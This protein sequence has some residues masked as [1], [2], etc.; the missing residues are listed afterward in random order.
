MK[1][2]LLRIADTIAHHV[3]LRKEVRAEAKIA[4]LDGERIYIDPLKDQDF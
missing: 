2:Q 3:Y 1:P 4:W